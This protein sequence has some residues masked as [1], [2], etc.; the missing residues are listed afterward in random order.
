M[1]NRHKIFFVLSYSDSS[2]TMASDVLY[3]IEKHVSNT[4]LTGC[5]EH[6]IL[7][8]RILM[9]TLC[10]IKNSRPI[11]T[12]FLCLYVKVWIWFSKLEE[13]VKVR[14]ILHWKWKRTLWS[15]IKFAFGWDGRKEEETKRMKREPKTNAVNRSIK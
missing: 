4:L 5:F 6:T 2:A 10:S 7:W 13:R 11:E 14:V 8:K 9:W 1:T 12:F 3:E 15:N